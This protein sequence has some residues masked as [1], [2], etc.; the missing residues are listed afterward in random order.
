L[1]RAQ[2]DALRACRD[3]LRDF[4]REI[5][6]APFRILRLRVRAA[7]PATGREQVC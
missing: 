6:S 1:K 4:V 3:A 5:T 2:C 7:S